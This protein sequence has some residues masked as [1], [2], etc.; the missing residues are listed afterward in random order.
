MEQLIDQIQVHLV[1]VEAFQ[2]ND[3]TE[4]ENFRIKFLGKKGILTVLFAAFKEVP[5]DQKKGLWATAK[6]S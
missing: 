5:N 2:S 4:I 3:P 6:C 1:E